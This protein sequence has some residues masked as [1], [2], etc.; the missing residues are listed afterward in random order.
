MQACSDLVIKLNARVL[1]GPA[2]ADD[3]DF[4]RRLIMFANGV[5]GINSVYFAWPRSLWGIVSLIHPTIR[6]FYANLPE[7]KKK[8]VPD[9]RT[10]IAKLQA[11]AAQGKG[12][13]PASDEDITF[14][15]ALLQMHIEDGTMSEQ[16][17][18]LE[19][20]CMEAV[21]YTYE[22][23]GPIMP[24]L[25]FMI[26]EIGKNPGYLQALREEISSALGSNDWSSDFL[27]RTPK[28]ESFIREI[29]RLY[30][31]AQ[32]ESFFPA[33]FPAFQ[34]AQ[35]SIKGHSTDIHALTY[36]QLPSVAEQ[37]SLST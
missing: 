20:M 18:D 17:N 34:A 29:L 7:L 3:Q 4:H 12:N 33:S 15:T 5:D 21:F 8:L 28:F 1:Y 9:A 14:M 25:F 6:G 24:T 35:S 13:V 11:K 19:N 36:L 31:P 32:C 23:W 30:L 27:T 10:R 2:Y 22:F 37:R 16:E 26:M